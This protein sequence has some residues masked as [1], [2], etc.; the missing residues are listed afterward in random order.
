[1]K[2]QKIRKSLMVNWFTLIELLVVIAIIAILAGML[3]PVLNRAR[4]TAKSSRCVNNLKQLGLTVATYSLDYNDVLM[5]CNL[6]DTRTWRVYLFRYQTGRLTAAVG[7]N[8]PVLLCP[9]SK[10]ATMTLSVIPT[11]YAYNRSAGYFHSA[12][13]PTYARPDRSYSRKVSNVKR[14]SECVLWA[15]IYAPGTTY[16]NIQQGAS[17]SIPGVN[18]MGVGLIHQSA[19]NIGYVDGHVQRKTYYDIIN[20]PSKTMPGIVNEP[21]S[22]SWSY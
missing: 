1:M 9:S 5:P 22:F 20:E 7:D 18:F 10:A 14:P 8:I 4:E 19:A 2:S 21:L 11:G 3:L 17:S 13:T 15:D 12:S 16:Y 6:P